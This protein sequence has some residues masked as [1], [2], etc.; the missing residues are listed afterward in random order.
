MSSVETAKGVQRSTQSPDKVDSVPRSRA[1]IE[2]MTPEVDAGRFPVKRTVGEVVK[3]EV[4]AFTDG[5]DTLAVVLKYRFAEEFAEEDTWHEVRM[6]P[7]VN[8]RWEAQFPVARLGTYRYTAEAWIDRFATWRRDLR[9]RIAAGQDV[10]QELLVGAALVDETAEHATPAARET[11]EDWAQRMRS[12]GS[13]DDAL[14]ICEDEELGRLMAQHDPRHF[15]TRYPRELS[16]TVEREKARFSSWYEF[17]P[18][19]AAA[20]PGQHGT[21]QDCQ[22]WLP[23][24][25]KMGFDVV[26]FPPIHPIGQQHRKGKNNSTS[27]ESNDVGSPWAIGSAE[28]GHKAIHPAL[29]TLEDFHQLVQAAHDHDIEI[30]LDIALQCSPDHPYVQEH[31][32]W[33]RHRPDGSIQFAENPPKKYQDIYPFDFENDSWEEM[34]AELKSIF[35]YWCEQGVRIFRVDNPHTKPLNFWHWTISEVKR[36]Y[37]DTVFLSEAFTRPKLMY[38]LAKVG[39]SQSYTYFSWRQTKWELTT[40]MSE[41]ARPPVAEYFRPNLWPNTPDI[42]TEQLQIGDRQVYAA[43]LVLAATLGASYGIYGPAFELME[44]EPREYGSEEYRDSEKYQLRH[45]DLKREDS[46]DDF[47]AR[48]NRIRRENPALQS[49]RTLEFH[50]T[51]NEQLICYSKRTDAQDDIVVV[52]VNLDP[53]HTQAGFVELPLD[54]MNLDDHRPYQMHD[55]LSG[56]RYL[57]HGQR[58]FVQIDPHVV[59]AHIFRVRRQVRTERDFEYFF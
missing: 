10:S 22:A 40:Y 43:R 3:V 27:A 54:A 20:E 33:F 44:K 47:I 13:L 17:F 52:V 45:R 49:N 16:V 1:A 53:H 21:F 24:V 6:R 28:G 18:R 38:R 32:E 5:H 23:Y 36:E 2:A 29:G 11:L 50:P 39:F 48:V 56:A 35:T 12:D 7:L 46:L 57:W 58:N 19:S 30:A 26:Y 25:A 55:E 14:R 8:D 37:P 4:D 51:D 41:V 34:W 9:K 59:P 15:K 42:L 31:A